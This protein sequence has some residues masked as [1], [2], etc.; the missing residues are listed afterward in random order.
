M[1]A[2]AGKPHRLLLIEGLDHE[3]ALVL[4]THQRLHGA[5]PE[6]ARR[7]VFVT[8]GAFTPAA[9]EF[10]DSVPNPVIPGMTRS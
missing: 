1:G 10:V 7:V 5:F 2:P 3:A 4:R 9:R 8:G 6:R